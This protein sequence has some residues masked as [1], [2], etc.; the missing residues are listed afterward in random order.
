MI[1]VITA[2]AAYPVTLTEAKTWARVDSDD[3][4]QDSVVNLLIA[5]MTDYA[6]HLTGR[7]F[8]ARTLEL[9]LPYFTGCIELPWVPLI[10]VT[11][12]AYTDIND[13]AQ[14]VSSADYEVDTVSQPGR[15][16]P[17]TGA[18]WPAIGT[19]F[20]PVRIRYQAGYQSP[21]SPL[22]LTDNS[23]LPAQLRTWIQ[24]RIATLYDNREHLMLNNQIAVPRDFC[25]GLLD[26][27]IIGSRLF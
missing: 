14:T 26:S 15:I 24:A 11:S 9:N 4:S 17:V 27:L 21:S 18:S 16:R 22:D 8:V 1:K 25:D 19:L 13:A 5:A 6:E 10:S 20:N 3:T 12:I 7:A 23:Y 2:P